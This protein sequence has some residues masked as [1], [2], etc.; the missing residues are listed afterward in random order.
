MVARSLRRSVART[1]ARAARTAACW[2]PLLAG[3]AVAADTEQD[4]DSAG[5]GTPFETARHGATPAPR[6]ESGGLLLV[7]GMRADGPLSNSVAF[8]RTADA[9]WAEVE[10]RFRFTLSGGAH[11]MGVALL[12]TALY[13]ERGVAPAVEA[14][15]EPNL[16]GTFAVGF[17][18]HD[19][20]T[21]HWFDEFG[22]VHDR[23]QRQLSLHWD[24]REIANRLSEVEFRD[25]ESHTARIALRYVPGGALVTVEIDEQAVYEDELVPDVVPYAARLAVG[26]RTGETTVNCALDDVSVRW[27]DRLSPSQL[28]T[29]P[30]RV[31]LFDGVVMNRERRL[32]RQTVEL[33][34]PKF[35]AA[36]VLLR[37]TVEPGPGGWDPWDRT[38]AIYTYQDGDEEQRFEVCRFITPFK[39]TGTWTADVTDYRSLLRGETDLGLFVDSWQEPGA[40]EPQGTRITVELDFFEGA[41]ELEAFAVWN[42][43]T[44][45][46]RFG[47]DDDEIAAA[48]PELNVTLPGG[49]EYERVVI[50]NTVTGHGQWGEFQPATRVLR[51]GDRE[52]ADRLW[53]TDVFLNPCRPQAGT[54]KFDR[55]GWAPG[56]FVRPWDLDVTDL[57]DPGETVSIRYLPQAWRVSAGTEIQAVHRV[58]SQ[59]VFYRRPR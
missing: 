23:P 33:P 20:P 51:Y 22:N 38:A 26:A 10:I 28:P 37:L 43:W 6:Q 47:N 3:V 40:G 11:G 24:G 58:E 41:P 46:Y 34:G 57:A 55:A 36:R 21:R 56:A 15:E 2:L 52:F 18:V 27:R 4:F 9:L 53:T 14:W 17:D 39:R 1:L 31:R 44:I 30:L 49:D 19:P 42:L 29:G 45:D 25:D 50:R 16:P 13:G 32:E 12:P 35:S 7:D 54:W 8:E 5:R 48:F 59:L